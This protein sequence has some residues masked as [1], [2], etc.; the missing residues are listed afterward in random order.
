MK[1]TLIQYFEVLVCI[2]YNEGLKDKITLI[3]Y[4]EFLNCIGYNEGLKER[5]LL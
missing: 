1:I 4:F 2:G 5:R 3:Q